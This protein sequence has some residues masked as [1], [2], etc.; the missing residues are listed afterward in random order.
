MKCEYTAKYISSDFTT[1]LCQPCKD[2]EEDSQ[3]YIKLSKI[4]HEIDVLLDQLE[5]TFIDF[6]ICLAIVKMFHEEERI[7]KVGLVK[8]ENFKKILDED[9]KIFCNLFGAGTCF[10]LLLQTDET[11]L[12]IYYN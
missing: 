12:R 8:L 9:M 7:K 11:T 2:S 5:L 1:I 6:N 4:D 3:E 10:C